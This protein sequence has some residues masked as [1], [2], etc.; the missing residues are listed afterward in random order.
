MKRRLSAFCPVRLH[1]AGSPLA[2]LAATA[3]QV[4]MESRRSVIS[5]HYTPHV[6]C[7]SIRLHTVRALW[8]P[9]STGGG[10]RA[11]D[12]SWRCFMAS[13]SPDYTSSLCFPSK[14]GV[15]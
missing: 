13:Q 3:W 2:D 6:G 1:L 10:R 4:H 15:S 8:H 9:N 14:P 7:I 12:A 11:A 5:P